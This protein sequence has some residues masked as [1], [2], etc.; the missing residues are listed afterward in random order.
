MVSAKVNMC[1]SSNARGTQQ[2]GGIS[3]HCRDLGSL[4]GGRRIQA[5]LR[6]TSDF[7]MQGIKYVCGGRI[8]QI[9]IVKLVMNLEKGS[10]ARFT[11]QYWGNH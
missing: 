10:L 1:F 8:G 6:V 7:R 5:G 4:G 11:V 2:W 3:P 9:R